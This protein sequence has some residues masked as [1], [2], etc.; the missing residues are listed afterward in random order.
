VAGGVSTAPWS[1]QNRLQTYQLK[2]LRYPGT[3]AQLKAFSDLGLFDPA[4]IRVDGVEISPRRV[5]ETLFEPQVRTGDN[6]DVCIIRARAVGS[7][8]GKP[9]E[10]VVDLVDYFDEA[11]QF[12][13]M[14]RTTGWHLSTV[15]SM[16]A[17]GKVPIGAVPL[18]LAFPGAEFVAEARKRGFPITERVSPI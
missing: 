17:H 6:R 15:A 18:E 5:F 2:I 10:A 11:T 12:T 3:F 1:F 16:I 13:A 7:K 9:A 8:D 14:Q 4:P